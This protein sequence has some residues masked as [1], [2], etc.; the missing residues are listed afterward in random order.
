[1][2]KL[3]IKANATS[4]T[5]ELFIQ[6]S[7]KTTGAGLTGLAYNTVG[8]TC[9]YSFPRGASTAVTLATLASPTAAWASGGFVEIDST[10]KPGHYRFDIPNALLA[11][12]NGRY[13][14]LAFRGAANMAHVPVEIEITG[15]DNQ[16]AVHGGMSAL[17]NAA[18][19]SNASL[20][21]SGSGTD[22]LTVTGG[23]ASSDAKKINAVSTSSVT[24][25]NANVGTTQPTNYTGTGAS[26][27]VKSDMVD[28]AGAA[29]SASTAQIG[30]NVVQ[31]NAVST[32][33]VTA[34]NAN[35]GTTQPINF[36]GTG[37]SAYVKSDVTEWGNSAVGSIPP[38]A[39]FIRGGTAQ[40]GGSNTITLDSGASAVN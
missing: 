38:D 39:V 32:S 20:I 18:C 13:V 31:V 23:I 8:L 27:L 5:I 4:E 28:I 40:A 26:A 36:D 35:L 3:S 9:Y 37:A 11:S 6:D 10:N 24:T 25:I 30:V 22:Q 29:V 19:T 14:T 34:V 16:D 17:P 33:S 2:A 12:G 1:M 21:T 7:S 15:W